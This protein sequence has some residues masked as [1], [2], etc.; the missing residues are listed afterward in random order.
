MSLIINTLLL[1]VTS[2]FSWQFTLEVIGRGGS[3][4]WMSSE[5]AIYVEDSIHTTPNPQD[6][7]TKEEV[8]HFCELPFIDAMHNYNPYEERVIGVD[9]TTDNEDL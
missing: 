9:A 8:L 5:G 1:T 3:R 4:M 2:V 6:E 7:T